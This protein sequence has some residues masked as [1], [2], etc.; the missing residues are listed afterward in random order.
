MI[1]K[2]EIIPSVGMGAYFG[3]AGGRG[4]GIFLS[5]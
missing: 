4:F 2:E 5:K 1:E 3:R